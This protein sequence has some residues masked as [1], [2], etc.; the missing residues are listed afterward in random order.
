MSLIPKCLY[1][2]QVAPTRDILPKFQ[3]KFP[4][5]RSEHDCLD[6]VRK[7]SKQLTRIRSLEPVHGYVPEANRMTLVYALL[8]KVGIWAYGAVLTSADG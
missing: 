2:D 8:L 4:A 6:S 7:I 1:C 3:H 5:L